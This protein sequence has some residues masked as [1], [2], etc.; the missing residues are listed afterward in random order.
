M[1]LESLVVEFKGFPLDDF[2]FLCSFL[3]ISF[4]AWPPPYK[5]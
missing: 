4:A 5:W 3:G 2:S 1:F